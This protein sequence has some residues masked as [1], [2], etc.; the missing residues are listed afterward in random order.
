M[1]ETLVERMN[2]S[3]TGRASIWRAGRFTWDLS[4][5]AL[6]MGILN[7]TPDSFSDGG[8]YDTVDKAVGHAHEMIVEGADILDIGGESTR[9]G[10]R[11]VT[12]EEELSRT[13]PVIERIRGETQ[14]AIS[15]DT[16]KPEVARAALKAGADIINDVTCFRD[17]E[18]KSLCADSNCGMVAMHMQGSPQT[19]QS[20]PSYENVV[21]EVT[22][23]FSKLLTELR[24]RGVHVERVVLDPGIGFG[25]LLDHNLALLKELPLLLQLHR[26]ILIGVSRKSFIGSLL[27]CEPVVEREVSTLALSAFTRI[28]GGMIHRVHSSAANREALRM[29]EAVLP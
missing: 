15:I 13:I 24:E 2:E 28:Q 1:T 26:P 9:P 25:K 20:S 22:A 5:K 29:T 4:E 7:V 16:S 23:S 12:I 8:S 27:G 17:P 14:S 18:M 6:V 19:M 10:S 11:S 3:N 21:A